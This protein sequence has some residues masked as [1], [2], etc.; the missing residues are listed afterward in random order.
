M[1]TYKYGFRSFGFH[2]IF[3]NF[4]NTRQ[5]DSGLQTNQN[6]K[7]KVYGFRRKPVNPFLIGLVYDPWFYCSLDKNMNITN[8]QR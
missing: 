2:T 6:F 7:I 8:W 3:G 5:K 4:S 1:F